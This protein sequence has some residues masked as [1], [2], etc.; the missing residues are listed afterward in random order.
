[1]SWGECGWNSVNGSCGPNRNPQ[2]VHDT[3]VKMSS[4]L[5]LCLAFIQRFLE[6]DVDKQWQKGMVWQWYSLGQPNVL[7]RDLVPSVGQK[8]QC[9][10]GWSRD[11]Y[12]TPAR[13]GR[14]HG[15]MDHGSI[16][17]EFLKC[18][19][20]R[21]HKNAHLDYMTFVFDFLKRK[22]S[23]DLPFWNSEWLFRNFVDELGDPLIR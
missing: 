20:W 21:K 3:S 11:Q 16:V 18:L 22:R 10:L 15:S 5:F 8:C 14:Q 13:S 12:V 6:H 4:S 19:Y 9:R 1:M 17:F 2:I 7:N 23:L